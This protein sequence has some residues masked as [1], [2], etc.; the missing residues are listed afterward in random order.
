M[1]QTNHS[2]SLDAPPRPGSETCAEGDARTSAAE[3]D[4]SVFIFPAT[5]AQRRFWLLDQVQPGGNPAF[6]MSVAMRWRGPLDRSLLRRALNEV[7]ARHEALRTTFEDE[8]GQLRQL[9]APALV[10]D[11]TILDATAAGETSASDLP[12]QLMHEEARKP[13]DLRVGPLLR[14]AL[15]PLGSTEHLLVITVHHIV[16]DGWSNAILTRDLCAFYTALMQDKPAS[17]PALPIQF[18]DYAEWQQARLADDDFAAQREY[19]RQHLAGDLP[20]LDLPSDRPRRAARTVSGDVRFRLLS[21]ELVGAAKALGAGENASPFMIFFA[22]FQILL[23]RYTSKTDFLVTSPSANRGRRELEPLVG[24]FVNPLLLRADLHGDPTFREL[25][26]RVRSVALEAFSNQDIPF[27]SLLDEFHG[28][29]LQV[30][31]QYDSGLPQLPDLPEGLTIESVPAASAGTVY[32]LSVAILEDPRGLRLEFEYDTA[33]FDA[34]TI[35]RMLGHY[36]MLLQNA[37]ADPAQPISALPLLTEDEKRNLG[38]DVAP[39]AAATPSHLD[40][41]PPLVERVMEKPDAVAARHGRRE[42]SCAELLARMERARN[43]DKSDRPPSDLDQAAAWVAHWRA[44]V[45][46]APPPV[47]ARSPEVEAAIAAASLALREYAGLD[48]KSTRLNSSHAG[49]SR[50]PSSA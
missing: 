9:I 7:V 23:C 31:F 5:S 34:E 19:W 11:L 27:E 35:D 40:I 6:N 44:R 32:E 25:L 43:T 17:L 1:N 20:G 24:L 4:D 45:D 14:A 30:N 10:L 12:A 2:L 16:S 22:I 3:K 46:T 41:R 28:A 21:R 13:F 38:L 42:L 49:L 15:L 18:A 39:V 50:M 29:M 8:R 47:V 36:E 33:L 48:R 37:V 26:G